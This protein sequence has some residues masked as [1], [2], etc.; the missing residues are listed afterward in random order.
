ML[1]INRICK[2]AEKEY[3]RMHILQKYCRSDF[4][5]NSNQTQ[6]TI[7]TVAKI[8]KSVFYI[9]TRNLILILIS[10]LINSSFHKIDK[11]YKKI[12]FQHFI[13]SAPFFFK[14]YSALLID[15]NRIIREH[16]YFLTQVISVQ[17]N[18]LF[19]ESILF[20]FPRQ[21]AQYFSIHH[22]EALRTRYRT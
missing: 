11:V 6:Y 13:S 7:F 19:R 10:I 3:F 20:E 4:L 22:Q 9:I 17:N 8:S 12:Y 14:L 15:H 18:R 2:C 5:F 1:S 16:N 21:F